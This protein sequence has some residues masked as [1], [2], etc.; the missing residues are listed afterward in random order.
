MASPRIRSTNSPIA[1]AASCP[2]TGRR[3]SNSSSASRCCK[4]A[5]VLY[6]RI[7][8]PIRSVQ[9]HTGSP[10]F[11]GVLLA[12]IRTDIS[13]ADFEAG[14]RNLV[15][16]VEGAYWNLY[17][18]Y[19]NLEARKV[20]RDSAFATWNKIRALANR[21]LERWRSGQRSTSSRAVLL[22][23]QR[24]RNGA[25]PICSELRTAAVHHG[26]GRDRRP[27]DR[28][29]FRADD[30]PRRVRLARNPRRMR[31]PATSSCGSNGGGSSSASWS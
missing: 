29:N 19:R 21:R 3:T 2:A 31:S 30:G 4:A 5:G 6:N 9:R 25:C 8:G 23:P 16:D 7:A 22:L 24:S 26:L 17:F 10:N 27:F 1:A 13:L 18:A 20:G 14:I 11:D 15:N 12:S 28:A